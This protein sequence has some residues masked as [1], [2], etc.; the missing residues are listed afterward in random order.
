MGMHGEVL[1]NYVI[2]GRFFPRTM[3]PWVSVFMQQFCVC[4]P[5]RGSGQVFLE[6]QRNAVLNAKSRMSPCVLPPE[7][8]THPCTPQ[9]HSGCFSSVNIRRLGPSAPGYQGEAEAACRPSN[10]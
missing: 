3:Y 5:K 1:F 7:T 8:V 2:L 6:L 9:T 4:L 10:S